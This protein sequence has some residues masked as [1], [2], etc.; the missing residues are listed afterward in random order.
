MPFLDQPHAGKVM[1]MRD[2][3][4]HTTHKKEQALP[5]TAAPHPQW[6][7]RLLAMARG[8]LLGMERTKTQE[9]L[10]TCPA[11]QAAYDDYHFITE[12][13][14]GEAEA[15]LFSELLQLEMPA[16]LPPHLSQTLDNYVAGRQIHKVEPVLP[17]SNIPEERGVFIEASPISSR[18][19][20]IPG[21]PKAPTRDDEPRRGR[22]IAPPAPLPAGAR[23]N[24]IL[25][26]YKVMT[27]EETIG[28]FQRY[29][30]EPLAHPT[31]VEIHILSAPLP[32]TE[33]GQFLK[34]AERLKRLRHPHIVPVIDDGIEG[35]VA[36]LVLPYIPAD[37][38]RK[39]HPSGLSLAPETVLSYVQQIAAALTYA[40]SRNILHGNIKPENL[41]A[42]S[43]GSVLVTHFDLVLSSL[44]AETRLSEEAALPLY[45]APEQLSGNPVPASD[46]Y[47]LAAV[48]YEWLTG[49]PPFPGA[50][51][52]EVAE[53]QQHSKPA[54]LRRKRPA[55]PARLD[56]V[57]L[58]ALSK[59][60]AERYPTVEAFALALAQVILE[61]AAAARVAET[62]ETYVPLEPP[63]NPKKDDPGEDT[64]TDDGLSGLA[65]AGADTMI[66][67]G[68]S[69]PVLAVAWSTHGHHIASG[70]ADGTIQVWEAQHGKMVNRYSHHR[71][72]KI[73]ALSWALGKDLLASASNDGDV[74]IWEP[75]SG[76][77]APLVYTSYPKPLTTVA[78][79]PDNEFLACGRDDHTVHVWKAGESQ[80][81]FVYA[82]H[83]RP[84]SGLV[85]SPDSKRI[86]SADIGGA[87]HVWEVD[88]A[89]KRPI[90][91]YSEHKQS[92]LALA[93]S[94][95]GSRIA[96]GGDDKHIHIWKADNGTN[97][98]SYRGHQSTVSAL[99]WSPDGRYVASGDHEGAIHVWAAH[100]GETFM[101]LPNV[102]TNRVTGLAWSPA[103][104]NL[105][106]SSS[107]DGTAIR[108]KLLPLQA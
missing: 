53:R 75:K 34:E 48:A 100:T 16:E 76:K 41:L 104:N 44:P 1:K 38:L 14:G 65:L 102:H 77:N 6:N 87:V 85:W 94:P 67:D 97:I 4:Q 39:K 30:G 56:R 15:K 89:T 93:W 43:E 51:F 32:S 28:P 27:F 80:P 40:H 25:G 62:A 19:E 12:L 31:P 50:S 101:T 59:H 2:P 46:Q 70:G 26:K 79:S 84:L 20:H 36:Y 60:P 68:H 54:S 18:G 29:M 17:V 98:L 91:A 78:W 47:A 81:F 86:A 88:P 107:F 5:R 57:I 3:N 10:E 72:K 103:Q 73:T 69:G 8:K 63:P 21:A 52:A 71:K 74:H 96:S 99:D 23:A 49:N 42:R 22:V 55:L 13:I 7:D 58:K 90:V 9:H 11:C 105:L 61:P 83:A 33:Q 64:V 108:W 45:T 106:A 35:E 37:T 66:Y 92:V 95:N 24:S 82:G